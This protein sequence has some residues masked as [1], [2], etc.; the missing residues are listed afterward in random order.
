[1]GM[2]YTRNE[3]LWIKYQSSERPIPPLPVPG[4]SWTRSH[5][6]RRSVHCVR[7]R[8]PRVFGRREV[9]DFIAYGGWFHGRMLSHARCAR[10]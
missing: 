8:I 3:V 6:L 4:R 1:M 10:D 9:M 5:A 2:L 7:A